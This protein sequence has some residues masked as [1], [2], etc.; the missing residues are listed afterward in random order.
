MSRGEATGAQRTAGLVP[1]V[2]WGSDYPHHEGTWPFTTESLRST[3]AGFETSDVRLMLGE[4]AVGV[5]DLD[6]AKLQHIANRIGPTVEEIATP[7]EQRPTGSE[8]SRGFR[9]FGAYT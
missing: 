5:F 8:Y 7:L 3:F 9:Q 2:L 1:N 4:N 6:R